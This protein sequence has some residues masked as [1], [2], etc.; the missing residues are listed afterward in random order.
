MGVPGGPRSA[1]G[2]V[3]TSEVCGQGVAPR[4]HFPESEPE[5][6]RAGSCPARTARRPGPH[7][8]A[9]DSPPAGDC[10]AGSVN[11]PPLLPSPPPSGVR[12]PS[13][14]RSCRAL[15]PSPPPSPF[16]SWAATWTRDLTPGGTGPP[17][18]PGACS[19]R[20]AVRCRPAP[21]RPVSRAALGPPPSGSGAAP[22]ASPRP[23]HS[24]LHSEARFLRCYPAGVLGS[25]VP[26]LR[27]GLP[28]PRSLNLSS[29]PGDRRLSSRIPPLPFAFSS[30][31]EFRAFS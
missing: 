9:P 16:P 27:D 10:A 7:P 25:S 18:R 31:R 4:K 3:A 30:L 17:G 28:G 19:L 24:L 23:A 15:P 20:C 1:L 8:A 11:A 21:P 12:H 29:P 2:R 13:P 6:G 14:S 22:T 26:G 5:P